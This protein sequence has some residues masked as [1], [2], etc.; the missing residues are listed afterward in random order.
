MRAFKYVLPVDSSHRQKLSE[1]EMLA[2]L[3]SPGW[4]IFV[5]GLVVVAIPIGSQQVKDKHD[6]IQP[7]IEEV[8][9]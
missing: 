4:E 9:E 5:T 8:Q 1:I 7:P 6:G 3:E 2:D